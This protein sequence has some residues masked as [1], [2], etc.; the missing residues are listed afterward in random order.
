MVT[1]QVDVVSRGKDS[2]AW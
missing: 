1:C 2:M